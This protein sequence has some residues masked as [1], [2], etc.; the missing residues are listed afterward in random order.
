MKQHASWT[1]SLG[2]LMCLT[3]ATWERAGRNWTFGRGT[4]VSA[5]GCDV[6]AGLRHIDA[7]QDAGRARRVPVQREAR[8][9]Q[10]GVLGRRQ[11]QSGERVVR[12]GGV[13]T[14]SWYRSLVALICFKKCGLS[15]G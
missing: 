15:A 7:V 4:D 14:Y 13:S 11:G 10:M 5:H 1:Y 2:S 8:G 3:F 12:C 6:S 9:L